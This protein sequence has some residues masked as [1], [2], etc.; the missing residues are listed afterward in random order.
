MLDLSRI[1]TRITQGQAPGE[2]TPL[3]GGEAPAADTA[4]TGA[5]VSRSISA[6]AAAP[7]AAPDAR[8]VADRVYELLRRDALI[9]AERTGKT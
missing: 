2:M 3:G 1:V 5:P 8:A 4:G 6:A 7:E 9:A